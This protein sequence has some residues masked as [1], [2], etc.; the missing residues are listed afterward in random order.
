LTALSLCMLDL[1]HFLIVVVVVTFFLLNAL[2]SQLIQHSP[3]KGR[4]SCI[5]GYGDGIFFGTVGRDPDGL[6]DSRVG[7]PV[8]SLLPR[9]RRSTEFHYRIFLQWKL[10]GAEG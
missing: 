3:E 4:H 5:F 10:D 7:R 2:H 8:L 6:F 9:Y 1:T